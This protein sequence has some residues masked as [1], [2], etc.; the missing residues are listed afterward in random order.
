VTLAV[1]EVTRAVAYLGVAV[2]ALLVV[3]RAT[4]Q[5]LL[6]GVLGGMAGVTGYALATRLLPDHVGSWD[7]ADGYRLADPVGYWNGMGVYA[8][9]G[10]LLALGLVAGSSSRL[11]RC[12]AGAAP[13]V[14]VTAMLFTFSRGAW[15]A[16]AVGFLVAFALDVARL[17][18]AAAALVLAPWVAMPLLVATRSDVLT[19]QTAT[20]AQVVDE[21]HDLAVLVVVTAVVSAVAAVAFGEARDRVT[22]GPGVRRAFAAVLAA[23]ALAAAVGVTVAEGAPWTLA[24]RAWD[25]FTSG[26][27]ST[28]ADLTDRL[29]DLSNNGRIQ[30]WRVAWLSFE[31]HPAAGEG[32]GSFQVAWFR[33]RD[34]TVFVRDAHSLYAETLGELG[35]V[36]LALLAAAL[37]V[38]LVAAVRVRRDALLAAALA[39]YAAFVAHASVDWDWELAGV[40]VPAILVAAALVVRARPRDG[41]RDLRPVAAAA[42]AVVTGGLAVLSI[43]AVLANLPLDRAQRSYLAA[44]FAQADAEAERATRWAPWSSL[45]WQWRG[46]AQLA[47]DRRAEARVSFAKA[48]ERSP[49]DWELL[50]DA[51]VAEGPPDGTPL[52][53]RAVVLNPRD[54]ELRTLLAAFEDSPG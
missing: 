42:L 28:G 19:D 32:A 47:L 29:F 14:F 17:R 46:R 35:V 54:E 51:A 7:P 24:D 31:S 34:S 9:V 23:L 10:A 1:N 3:R 16:L 25:N 43:F 41:A 4:V 53:R 30:H 26:P 18:L 38:P 36:G 8:A 49:R 5:V 20:L 11:V 44:D 33:D 6:A 12:L 37:A 52:L 2:L 13:P 40:T 45:A 15:A 22:V 39:P 21:G 48:L 50:R 27:R